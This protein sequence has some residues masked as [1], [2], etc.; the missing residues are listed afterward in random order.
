MPAIEAMASGAPTLV[1]DLPV[2]R[3]V[4]LGAAHYLGEPL[5]PDAV[6]DAIDQVLAA[7]AQARPSPEMIAK[8]RRMFAPA[9]IARQYLDVLFPEV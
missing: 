9:T 5:N 3:E 8:M 6:C 1:S 7:G 4:T 2:F